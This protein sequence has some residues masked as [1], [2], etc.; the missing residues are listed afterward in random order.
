VI[1]VLSELGG[2]ERAQLASRGI[3]F[4]VINHANALTEEVASVGATNWDGGLT[5]TRHLLDLGH[6]RIG[7]I[8]GPDGMLCSRARVD[9]YR[10]ALETAGIPYDPLIIRAGNFDHDSG[11]V[12][13][14]ELL[15]LSD[16]PT[17][18]FSGNDL[19]ALA[20]YRAAHALGLSIP[21]DLS[22]VGFDDVSLSSWAAPSLTTVCQPFKQMAEAAARLVIDIGRGSAPPT[23]RLD[24]A[25]RLVVRHSTAAPPRL[26]PYLPTA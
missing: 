11:Y 10:T 6:Q 19:Q 12:A 5:A 9:G 3:P 14:L 24:L 23:E 1:L 13:G 26:E 4:V 22:V 21:R 20:V 18:I 15:Q 17:A 8:S 2:F 16:R 7:V 25:T